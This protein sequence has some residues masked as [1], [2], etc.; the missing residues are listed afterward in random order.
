MTQDT[1][2][3]KATMTSRYAKRVDVKWSHSQ[4][5]PHGPCVARPSSPSRSGGPQA[6]QPGAVRHHEDVEVWAAEPSLLDFLNISPCVCH[7]FHDRVVASRDCAKRRRL[8]VP[9]RASSCTTSESVGDLRPSDLAACAGP[10]PF[11]APS[12]RSGIVAVL[13]L[14]A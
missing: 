10:A 14:F 2:M 4:T 3:A 12:N 9:T 13:P 1:R 5:P 7:F 11:R 8:E 6:S